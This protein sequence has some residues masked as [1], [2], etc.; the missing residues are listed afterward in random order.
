MVPAAKT[1]WL[2]EPYQVAFSVLHDSMPS[3]PLRQLQRQMENALG[4][5][6]G[7]VFLEIEDQPM[8]SAT[9]AQVH[10]GIVRKGLARKSS[11]TRVA[12]KI[13]HRGVEKVMMN[14]LAN[15]RLTDR[16]FKWFGV[17]G[18][19]DTQTIL[20]QYDEVVADEFDFLKEID[21]MERIGNLLREGKTRS[22]D[23][24]TT[25]LTVFLL[26]YFYYVPTILLLY[27]IYR[28]ICR[29]IMFT[30]LAL[31]RSLGSASRGRTRYCL[32]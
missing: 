12:I 30:P 8:N 27:S 17:K 21:Y 16:L 23:I 32:R 24:S 26:L 6:L 1:D 29:S 10:R 22:R 20:Q 4:C 11:V 25:V 15:L 19:M 7:K 18:K 14:D 13:Q 28:V 31:Q 2:P 3:I 5:P 9:I